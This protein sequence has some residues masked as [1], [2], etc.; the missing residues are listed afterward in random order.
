MVLAGMKMQML[1]LLHA[2]WLE[3][4]G[5]R[6]VELTSAA[7]TATGLGIWIVSWHTQRAGGRQS[8]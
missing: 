3:C 1:L 5:N 8:F 6:G 2:F 4:G 7:L